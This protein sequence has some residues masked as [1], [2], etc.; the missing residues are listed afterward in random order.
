MTHPTDPVAAMREALKFYASMSSWT[1][2]PR[3][4]TARTMH[5]SDAEIDM[6]KRARDALA[7]PLPAAP[8]HDAVGDARERFYEAATRRAAA[9]KAL[10][11]PGVRGAEYERALADYDAAVHEADA[12]YDA[13]QALAAERA[14]SGKAP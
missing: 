12:T 11:Q 1:L 5:L 2:T 8:A 6:G 14:T 7:L 4:G 3:E 9:W 10:R 13:W